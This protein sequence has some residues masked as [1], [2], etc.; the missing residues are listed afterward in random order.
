MTRK[1]LL[2]VL[3]LFLCQ[4]LFAGKVTEQEALQKAQQFMQ[5]KTFQ[6]KSLRRAQQNVSMDGAFY[7]FNAEGNGGFV[8]VSADDRTEAIL[9]YAD[10]G[11]FDTSAMPENVRKW[12]EGYAE[13]IKALGNSEVKSVPRRTEKAA[14]E[15][16]ITCHWNQGSPYNLRCPDDEEGTSV[17]GCVATAMAQVMY[18]HQWP[19]EATAVIPA[20]KTW[21][22]GL[23]MPELPAIVFKWDKMKD[24][25]KYDETGEAAEAVAE[26]MLYCG[27][28]VEMDYTSSGSAANVSAATMIYYFGYSKT[29]KD[30]SRR[31]YTTLD[32]EN[33]IYNEVYNCRPVLYGGSSTSGGHEFVIDGYD[34][35]GF[36]HV[37]WGWGSYCDG[38]FLLSVLNPNGRG[39]GGGSSSDGYSIGQDAVIGLQPDHGEEAV[40]PLI[41]YDLEMDETTQFTRTSL[42]EDFTN[43]S[44]LGWLYQ[45]SGEDIINV[46]HSWA[47]YLNGEQVQVLDVKEGVSIKAGGYGSSVCTTV[48]FGAGL[49][50]GTYE[51]RSM[52]RKPG[53]EEWENSYLGWTSSLAIVINGNTATLMWASDILDA[54]QINDV[55]MKGVK[56]VGRD[57]TVLINLTNNGF[58]HEIPLYLWIDGEDEFVARGSAYVDNGQ[59]GNLT[60]TFQPKTIGDITVRLTTDNKGN[61][62]V[63]RSES[64]TIEQSLPQTLTGEVTID[65]ERNNTIEGT[66]INATFTIENKGKYAFDDEVIISLL[67]IDENGKEINSGEITEVRNLQ[68]AV[69]Q[70]TELN[71]TFPDLVEGQEYCLSLQYYSYNPKSNRVYEDWAAYTY[72]TVGTVLVAYDMDIIMTVKNVDSNNNIEGTTV[73][74][75]IAITNNSAYDYDDKITMSIWYDGNDGYVWWEKDQTF[76]VQVPAGQTVTL[77]DYEITNLTIGRS[78]CYKL[79]YLSENQPQYTWCWYYNTLVEPTAIRDV[80]TGANEVIGIYTLDGQR[81]DTYRK[82]VNIVKMANGRTRKVVVK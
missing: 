73:K 22:K 79:S 60:L 58:N 80:E 51:L 82:G 27:Q 45:W 25:Y 62:E 56:K 10:Q 28:A 76:N 43:I 67:P 8:I 29:A 26:L 49:D 61:N 53:T 72:C 33:M 34:G 47:L 54:I 7:I 19:Q 1:L 70:E 41:Y 13:Q 16:L 5:G 74:A 24:E 68:L 71:A 38:Y 4:S 55:T 50:D 2:G 75:D 20:Y 39:I 6:K 23:D 35:N 17:T 69:G 18:Y 81:I 15:P 36:F 9:A 78:Y 30:V 57:M 11:Y 65:G 59:T 32:W 44:I 12:L 31:N 3:A 63:W 46:D 14:V 37:N 64:M 48:N 42:D 21:E 52:V 66:T 40:L 77:E